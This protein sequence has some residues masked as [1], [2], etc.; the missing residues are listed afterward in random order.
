MAILATLEDAQVLPPEGSREADQ[1][2]HALIQ[3]QSAFLKSSNPSVRKF[4]EK[5]L[6]AYFFERA[7]SMEQF[8]QE[9]GWTSEIL[10]AVVLYAGYP[11]AWREPELLTGLGAFNVTR[12]DLQELQVL[13]DQGRQ[14]YLQMGRD[15]HDVFRMKRQ[16]MPGGSR[17]DMNR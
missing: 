1:V 10:E 7:D 12:S 8:F 3:F 11:G 15:I 4:F 2:V 9:H 6:A 14:R 13:F 16:A 5:A 17:L